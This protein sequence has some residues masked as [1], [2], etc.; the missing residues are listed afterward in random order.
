MFLPYNYHLIFICGTEFYRQFHQ[1]RYS[2]FKGGEVLSY[3]TLR[4]AAICVTGFS[5]ETRPVTPDPQTPEAN[6]ICSYF[7]DR[8]RRRYF[9]YDHGSMINPFTT[10]FPLVTTAIP[11]TLT[12]QH[13]QSPPPGHFNRLTHHEESPPH[14]NR[15]T[16]HEFER[17]FHNANTISTLQRYL[18]N[19]RSTSS[20]SRSDT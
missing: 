13:H 3:G 14:P 15:S 7:P 4:V 19:N 9:D 20:T 18:E 11:Q 6:I 1:H 8:S 10:I 5:A 12:L 16:H 17:P 2:R